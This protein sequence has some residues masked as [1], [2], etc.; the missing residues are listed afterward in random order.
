MT[1]IGA[2][3]VAVDNLGAR[4]RVIVRIGFPRY[5]G[6]FYTLKFGENKPFTGFTHNGLIDL[7]YDE[8]PHLKAGQPF[9]LWTIQ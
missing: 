3:V 8:D 7:V 5:R 9:P 2:K 1:A 4:Y 6:S